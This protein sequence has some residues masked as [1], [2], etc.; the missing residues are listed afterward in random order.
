MLLG[1]PFD[2]S[3]KVLGLNFFLLLAG[4]ES[5]VKIFFLLI[6]LSELKEGLLESEGHFCFLVLEVL[7][8]V[9]LIFSLLKT[10]V[11]F[12]Q[13]TRGEGNL[14]FLVVQKLFHHSISFVLLDVVKRRD[15]VEAVLETLLQLAEG[16]VTNSLLLKV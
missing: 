12:D 7:Y 4:D 15:L 10:L 16:F 2:P 9:G 1:L 14:L 11:S 5:V 8:K 6:R 13:N 3:K